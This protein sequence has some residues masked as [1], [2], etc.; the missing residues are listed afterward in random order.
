MKA[1]FLITGLNLL[2]SR[3]SKKCTSNDPNNYRGISLCDVSSKLYSSII[4][5]RLQELIHQKDGTGEWQAGF[6]KNYSTADHM[7]TLLAA[8]QKQFSFN[9]KLYVAFID[10]EKKN[11]YGLSL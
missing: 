3:F 1:C 2:F 7:L 6:K 5:S 10:F 8:L 9:C 11:F 4:N